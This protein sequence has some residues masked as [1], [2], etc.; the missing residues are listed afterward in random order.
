MDC[1]ADTTFFVDLFRGR[2]SS[3][4][5]ARFA[6]DHSSLS[7]G[8][9]WIVRYEFLRG[10]HL[11]GQDPAPLAAFMDRYQIVFPD[12]E[13]IDA[14]CALYARLKKANRLIGP[15]D[16]WIAASALRF[17]LPLLTR[18]RDEFGRV[19]DLKVIDYNR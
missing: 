4:P 13:T 5:A 15:H 11:A 14:A 18:N 1:L 2:G 7:V 9:P 10:A 16:L 17:G 12:V 8:I 3:G 6:A 19:P